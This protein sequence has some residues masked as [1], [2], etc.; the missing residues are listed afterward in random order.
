MRSRI[1]SA[2]VTSARWF[3][4]IDHRF[5]PIPRRAWIASRTFSSTLRFGNRLVSWNAR[6]RPRR[7]RS[8]AGSDVISS[9]PTNTRPALAFNCPEIRLK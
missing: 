4:Q 6:P 5:S 8:G 3:D 2:S 7:V 9:P 1:A